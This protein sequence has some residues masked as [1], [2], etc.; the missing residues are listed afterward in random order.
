M[1]GLLVGSLSLAVPLIFGA[2]GG[3]L[4]ERAGV[5]NIAIEGQL[6]AG[7]FAGGGRRVD[8]QPATGQQWLAL[9]AGAIAAMVAGML[10]SL[11]LAVFGIKYIVDQV[12]VGVV[13]NVLVVGLTSFLY[14][15]VLSPNEAVL[16]TPPILDRLPIPM[17]SEIPIIGPVFFKQT[18]I[19][20]LM[21]VAI[22][23]VWFALYH[24]RW[25]LRVRAVGE[26]PQAAD[27]VGINVNRTRFWNVITRR[28]DRRRSAARSSPSA[29]S[30]RSP[31]R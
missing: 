1:I 25:G 28:R 15:E 27:T 21:Y 8:R 14:C 22:A 19:V 24:T 30:A 10:V 5:V 7:A 12:I 31:R 4:C 29:R 20:Y 17:L 2:L 6:L 26:H 16:N 23:V 3:V 13:L 9:T 18:I 11:L